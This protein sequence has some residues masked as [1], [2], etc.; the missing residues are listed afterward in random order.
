MSLEQAIAAL[1]AHA[2]GLAGIKHAP[3]RPPDKAA[4]FPFAVTY[5]SRGTLTG[6]A[7][8][9]ILTDEDHTIV[10]EIHVSRS[11]GLDPAVA[12]ALPYHD[13][14]VA[15]V[16]TDPQLANSVEMIRSLAYE[17]SGL[18]WAAEETI[19]YRFTTTVYIDNC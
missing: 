9:E 6:G 11:A 3:N 18:V 12:N 4:D 1:Q 8:G 15:S 10:T 16:K 19:G 14:F 17:F 13:L 7:L 2:N 5:A